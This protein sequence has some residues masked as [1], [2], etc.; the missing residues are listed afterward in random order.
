M[1][2]HLY[3]YFIY[4]YIYIYIIYILYKYIQT[5]YSYIYIV[6]KTQCVLPLYGYVC[7][8]SVESEDSR[9][10]NYVLYYIYL[11]DIFISYVYLCIHTYTYRQI[12]SNVK[13][14]TIRKVIDI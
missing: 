13:D 6:K 9:A 5:I 8:T 14:N 7:L 12:D 1:Y 4:I 10:K 3:I 2:T 11:L